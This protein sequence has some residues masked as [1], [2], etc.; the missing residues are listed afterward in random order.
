MFTLTIETDNSAFHPS[1]VEATEECARILRSVAERL[2][3]GHTEGPCL[4]G[5]G[6]RVG[7]WRLIF[8]ENEL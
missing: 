1:E 6:N 2:D 8:E 7:G 5:N 3:R 4:D